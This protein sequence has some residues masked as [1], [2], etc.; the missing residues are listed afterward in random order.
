[1]KAFAAKNIKTSFIASGLFPFNLNRVLNSIPKLAI[2]L[3]TA[4]IA[5]KAIVGPSSLEQLPLTP[6]T[7]VLV[8]GLMSL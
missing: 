8:E 4:L 7:L 2:G 3:F 6:V 5:N 1:M